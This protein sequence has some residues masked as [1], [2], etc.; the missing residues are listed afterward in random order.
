MKN[1]SKANIVTALKER[2]KEFEEQEAGITDRFKGGE[3]DADDYVEE[4]RKNREH[5]ARYNLIL[6]KFG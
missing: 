5:I 2:K 1:L 6:H 4:F 3:L